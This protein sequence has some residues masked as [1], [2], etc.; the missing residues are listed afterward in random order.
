MAKKKK[1]ISKVAKKKSLMK[2]KKAKAAKKILVKKKK[3]VEKRI[4][5]RKKKLAVK[6][7]RP[8]RNRKNISRKIFRKKKKA[9]K[10]VGKIRLRKTKLS[11]K[12]KKI[13]LKKAIN[14]AS[15]RKEVLKK[16]K[17][18]AKLTKKESVYPVFQNTL[19]KTKIKVIGIGGG[20]GSIVSEIGR[21]IGKASFIIADTDFRALKKR[22]GIKHFW[23]GK[24]FTHGLGSGVNPDLAKRAAEAEKEKIADLFRDQNIVILIASLGGGLGSGATQVFAEVAKSFGAITFGIF[25]VPFKFEGKN[26]SRIAQ[27]AL[28]ELSHFLNVS[29]VIPNERIFKLIDTNT[30]IT[31]AF[32]KV[33]K[34]LIESLESLIDLI[35][36]PGLINIDFADLKSIL[37]GSGNSAFLNTMQAFGKDRAT[38]TAEK[39]LFNP[40]YQS[41]SFTAENILFNVSGGTDL[42]MFEVEKIS[43]VIS[44]LNPRAK[45]IF[46]ISR[47]SG[48]RGFQRSRIK[49][50]I[51]AT[52][53]SKV[54]KPVKKIAEKKE[55][56]SP[57]KSVKSKKAENK[58]SQSKKTKL[59]VKSKKVSLKD[60]KEKLVK[61]PSFVP[62][63]ER[64]PATAETASK[65]SVINTG[66]NQQ[67]KNIRRNALEIKKA[68]ALEQD[69]RL[70]Q[71]EEWEIPAFLRKVKFKS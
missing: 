66:G 65:L 9:V 35:Y 18:S 51:L 2:M 20:G 49:T 56:P 31:E 23:F 25:T 41:N 5:K 57:K 53:P 30:P 16:G 4:I 61:E 55:K 69:K 37:S 60:K 32:S 43:N 47:D 38:E 1:R 68:E 62:I 26:K 7:R 28:Q 36:N 8:V 24:D 10:R 42:N 29:I 71:E 63:F 46:G 14:K 58:E 11:R 64:A 40:L 6:K 52:G 21:S 44:Q 13:I 54:I 59:K 15:I 33:N 12:K 50:T 70:I 67:K 27:K 39:I 34:N 48:S 22:S 17:K 45:I 3:S 19:F